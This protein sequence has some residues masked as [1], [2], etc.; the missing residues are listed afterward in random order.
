M[1][2]YTLNYIKSFFNDME[3]ENLL[4]LYGHKEGNKTFVEEVQYISKGIIDT[5]E[6]SV[7]FF[8]SNSSD[9]LGYIHNHPNLSCMLSGGDLDISDTHNQTIALYCQGMILWYENRTYHLQNITGG[10]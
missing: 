6:T 8:M 1:N 5:N 3:N 10:K 7:R 2:D 9:A 4:Y